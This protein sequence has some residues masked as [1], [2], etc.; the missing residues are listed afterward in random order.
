MRTITGAY[1][2]VAVAAASVAAE[3]ITLRFTATV[4]RESGEFPSGLR[5]LKGDVVSGRFTFDP[6]VPDQ[7]PN[8]NDGF[9]HQPTGVLTWSTS[10]FRYQSQIDTM[11]ILVANHATDENVG[12]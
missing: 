6:P 1:F 4:D 3:P 10:D 5:F 11:D 7:D 8:P 9:Y 2:F 12:V